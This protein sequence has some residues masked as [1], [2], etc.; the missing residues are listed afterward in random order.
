[1]SQGIHFVL[2]AEFLSAPTA[3]LFPVKS[4]EWLHAYLTLN[5]SV[6]KGFQQE[7]NITPGFLTSSGGVIFEV[8]G[9]EL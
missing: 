5:I 2:S 7:P 4:L 9:G 8:F 6:W 1:L 3:L